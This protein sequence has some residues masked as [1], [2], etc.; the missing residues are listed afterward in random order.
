MDSAARRVLLVDH[1]KF[2]RQGL[3]TLAPLT[4][5]DTVLVDDGLPLEETAASA[6]PEWHSESS[7]G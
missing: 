3:Y 6:T 7:D 5:F 1:T 4:A 2:S